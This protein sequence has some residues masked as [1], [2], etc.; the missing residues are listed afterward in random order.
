MAAAEAAMQAGASGSS[1]S[2]TR[3]GTLAGTLDMT[4]PTIA[5][6]LM[7]FASCGTL[8]AMGVGI[9]I[10]L[11]TVRICLTSQALSC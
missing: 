8:V 10:R 6:A 9:D 3:C 7:L 2:A 4:R 11:G 1:R 5:I